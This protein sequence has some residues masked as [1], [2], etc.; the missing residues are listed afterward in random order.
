VLTD[1]KTFKK[2]ARK[3]ENLELAQERWVVYLFYELMAVIA[4][5]FFIKHTAVI[6]RRIL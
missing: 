3:M 5:Q 6:A 4:F 1:V 2:A